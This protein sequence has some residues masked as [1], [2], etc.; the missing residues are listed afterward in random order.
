MARGAARRPVLAARLAA[1]RLRPDLVPDHAGRRLGGRVSQQHVPDLRG[2]PLP[3]A[4]AARA[5]EPHVPGGVASRAPS[6]PRSGARALVSA[7]ALRRGQRVESDP[8]IRV[9]VRRSTRPE[10]DLAEVRGSWR[11]EPGWPLE[12]TR[13][14]VLAA[15]P[16]PDLRE[17]EI[18]G[19][20]G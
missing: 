2:A 17:L 13:S 18:R 7:L 20:I 5:L 12:R 10:P 4:A 14:E 15:E 1:S 3:E 8:P 9:F 6:R 16:G 11:F 19:D